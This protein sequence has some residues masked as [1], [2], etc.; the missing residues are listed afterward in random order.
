MRPVWGHYGV[1]SE[2]VIRSA[3]LRNTGS[4]EGENSVRLDQKKEIS[5]KVILVITR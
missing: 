4:R 1:L 5:W 2:D 3:F